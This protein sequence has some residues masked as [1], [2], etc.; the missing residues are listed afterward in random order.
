M[1][2]VGYLYV[3]GY[4][5]HYFVLKWSNITQTQTGCSSETLVVSAVDVVLFDKSINSTANMTINGKVHP[6]T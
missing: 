4:S 2:F 6:G 5:G 1:H 3:M